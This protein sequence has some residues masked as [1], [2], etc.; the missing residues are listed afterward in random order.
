MGWLPDRQ[1]KSSY[2]LLSKTIPKS[3]PVWADFYHSEGSQNTHGTFQWGQGGY[4]KAG[5][6]AAKLLH[7]TLTYK[8]KFMNTK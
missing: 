5:L 3:E 4:A 2:N 1:R 8:Y 7:Y 6:A